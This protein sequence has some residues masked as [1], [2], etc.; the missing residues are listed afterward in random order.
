MN[1]II[2]LASLEKFTMLTNQI[3]IG[4]VIY[5]LLDSQ[6][7]D[8]IVSII[9]ADQ[10]SND[11]LRCNNTDNPLLIMI[12]AL[13]GSSSLHVIYWNNKLGKYV[14]DMLRSAEITIA[15]LV[16]LVTHPDKNAITNILISL[17]NRCSDYL[18]NKTPPL[19]ESDYRKW[20]LDEELNVMSAMISLRKDHRVPAWSVDIYTHLKKHAYDVSVDNLF[21]SRYFGESESANKSAVKTPEIKSE[22]HM[23]T[24]Q[25]YTVPTERWLLAAPDIISAKMKHGIPLVKEETD[26]MQA[27]LKAKAEANTA[28]ITVTSRNQGNN[29]GGISGCEPM[30]DDHVTSLLKHSGE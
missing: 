4:H 27:L 18:V 14:V 5:D 28:M 2:N 30:A 26:F 15:M 3:T 16:A 1:K 29:E 23:T 8:E 19:R 7:S 25:S 11:V 20:S 9:N 6:V 21:P 24:V 12:K 10:E 22:L 13:N 17:H